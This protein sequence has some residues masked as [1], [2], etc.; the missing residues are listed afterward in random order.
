MIRLFERNEQVFVCILDIKDGKYKLLE[1]IPK[2]YDVQ[3]FIQ[4]DAWW[5]VIKGNLSPMEAFF[6]QK[7]RISAINSDTTNKFFRALINPE[8]KN[9]R[10][11]I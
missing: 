8:D 2:K 11:F 3:L 7:M 6:E 4:K 9:K 1:K 5:E 10:I